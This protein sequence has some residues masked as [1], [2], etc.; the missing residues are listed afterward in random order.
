M[1]SGATVTMSSDGFYVDD[2]PPDFLMDI[3]SAEIYVDV[4]QGAFKPVRFQSSNSTIKAIWGCTDEES[5]VK[6]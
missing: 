5:D 1:G 2:T 4:N 6:V 3:M